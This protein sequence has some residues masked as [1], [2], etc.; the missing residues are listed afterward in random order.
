MI[1]FMTIA[2][3]NK[4]ADENPT[5]WLVDQLLKEASFNICAGGPKSGKSSLM[6]QLAVT[7]SKG[8]PFLDNPTK[9][10]DVLY[11]CPDEQDATELRR[12]F[13]QLGAGD[14]VLV[15]TFPVNRFSLIADLKDAILERP[16]VSLIVLDTLEKTVSMEDLN[17]YTKTLSDLEPLVSFATE[18]RLTVV[19]T[20]H[21][22]KR[23]STSVSG[24]MMGSNGIGSVATTSLEVLVDPTGKR[25]LRSM[26]RYGRELERTELH[27]D[28]FRL[29][30]NLGQSESAKSKDKAIFKVNDLQKRIVDFISTN[31][32]AQ[33]KAITDAIPANKQHVLRELK[34]ME[35]K[36]A[37]RTKGTGR[38]GNPLIYFPA[39]IPMEAAPRVI[40]A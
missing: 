7:V 4:Y 12:S 18:N 16:E 29:T 2:E 32:A 8:E 31:P 39:D 36:G 23:Q 15:S 38:R 19:G 27:F 28:P 14:G 26:Q 3:L 13:N 1:K 40:A 5:E 25:F 30:F 6:R 21:T 37:I 22:N 20:H 9:Q 17:D 33:Q 11:L 34:A 24:A 35:S 10:G